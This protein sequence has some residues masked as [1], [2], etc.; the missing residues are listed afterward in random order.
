MIADTVQISQSTASGASIAGILL[1][2]VL[3]IVVRR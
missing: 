2:A 1:V 3:V